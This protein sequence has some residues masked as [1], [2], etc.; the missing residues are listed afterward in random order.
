MRISDWSS[1][2]ALPILGGSAGAAF[3]PDQASLVNGVAGLDALGLG[4]KGRK[5]AVI[6]SGVDGDHADL[7]ARLVDEACFCTEQSGGC[8][9]NHRATQFGP[10]SAADD[11]GH[12]TNV[13]GII[14]EIRKSARLN[15]SP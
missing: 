1:A 13:A 9:P 3:A 5:V 15:S 12:G 11:Y 7:A 10:G 14:V 2:C 4:G 8:C 6:D